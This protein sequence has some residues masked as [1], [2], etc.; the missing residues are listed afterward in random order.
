MLCNI[1]NYSDQ[2]DLFLMLIL[3]FYYA[4]LLVY[5]PQWG[6]ETTEKYSLCFINSC[7]IRPIKENLEVDR[8]ER[9]TGSVVRTTMTGLMNSPHAITG[10]EELHC[11]RL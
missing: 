8:I 4:S 10:D 6:L 2:L 3:T 1:I 11:S 9:S 7:S 5:L